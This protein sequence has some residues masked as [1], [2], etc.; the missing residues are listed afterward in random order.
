MKQ[1]AGISAMLEKSF[2]LKWRALVSW[3]NVSL[4]VGHLVFGGVLFMFLWF[5]LGRTWGAEAFGEF[6]FLYAYAALWGIFFDFG[7]DLPLTRFV[8][9]QGKGIPASL[10]KIK[11]FVVAIGFVLSIGLAL[12][13]RLS[14][15]TVVIVLLLGVFLLSSTNF[16]NGLLRGLER[17]DIEAKIG[18]LQKAV[19]VALAVTGVLWYEK[20]LLWVAWSYFASHVL[21]LAFTLFWAAANC[22]LS[23][24]RGAMPSARQS[25]MGVIPFWL[26]ALFLTFGQRLDLFMLKG[27][28]D[29]SSVGIYSAGF[30]IIE[31]FIYIGAAFMTGF[32]PRLMQALTEK[33][34]PVGLI[35]RS[36]SFLLLISMLIA[37]VNY[38]AAPFL[39]KALYGP[40]FLPSIFV[41]QTLGCA[42]PLLFLSGLLGH[43]LVAFGKERLFVLALFLALLP[44]FF[45]NMVAIPQWGVKGAILGFWS[46]EVCLFCVLGTFYGMVKGGRHTHERGFKF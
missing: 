4:Q 17:L 33:K 43:A 19:F 28:L 45:V 46:R 31:G 25:V 24:A 20:G 41:L 14:D 42:L 13:L 10:V 18:F 35:R 22:S 37:L 29:A 12:V 3:G 11:F 38:F 6:N 21:G 7:L 27:L 9:A 32:F 23:F 16:I 26:I 30:R 15:L 2:F 1:G 34:S 44:D 8:S 40:S 39:V 36:A 5:V